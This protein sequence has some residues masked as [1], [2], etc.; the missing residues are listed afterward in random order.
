M[1]D[2]ADKEQPLLGPIVLTGMAAARAGLTGVVG[3]YLDAE[4][5]G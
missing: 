5:A 1:A 3:V 2:L 4:R